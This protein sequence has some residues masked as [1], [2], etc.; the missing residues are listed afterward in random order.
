[1]STTGTVRSRPVLTDYTTFTNEPPSTTEVLPPHSFTALLAHPAA[2]AAPVRLN[3]DA[4]PP[5]SYA[6]LQ[7]GSLKLI[8]IA[9]SDNPVCRVSTARAR[10]TAWG[11]S[12]PIV[13]AA[14]V[15]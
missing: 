6:P 14:D 3:L 10:S 7:A 15:T 4:R 9:R 12:A 11:V 13:I 5:T 2:A 8:E 1:M